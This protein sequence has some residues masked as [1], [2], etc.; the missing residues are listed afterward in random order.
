[1]TIIH[2]AC[3]K[4]DENA[5]LEALKDAETDGLVDGPVAIQVEA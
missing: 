2:I 1:M 4:Q 3:D 5:I